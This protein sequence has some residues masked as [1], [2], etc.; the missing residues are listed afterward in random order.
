MDF[1]QEW[2]DQAEIPV[3]RFASWL[4]ISRSKFYDWRSRYGK[5]NEHNA[6]I[7]RDHWLEQWERER[8]VE[9][10]T[11]N[12]L[13]GY[14]CMAFMMLD[15]DVVAVSPSSVYRVL[16]DA[17]LLER[18]NQKTSKKGT[19]FVQ[20]I[21]PHEHW[22]VDIT[23]INC[24]GTFYYLFVIVDGFSRYIIHWD[25]RAAMKETDVE[26]IIQE[27][28]EKFPGVKPRI[29]SDNGPQFI[30]R[31]FKAFIKFTGMTHVRTS[32]Y[33]PQSNGKCERVMKTLKVEGI[34]PAS[35]EDLDE[36]ITAVSR[37][38]EHYNNARLHSGIGYITPRDKL[39]GRANEIF[40]ERDRK[41]EE[42]R[43]QR[44][45]S[46]A[47][48]REQELAQSAA[49]SCEVVAVPA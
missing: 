38:V 23:Y 35:P 47:R 26:F 44:A 37:C 7:P 32:T 25:I 11:K 1:V 6:W 2:S 33:Y 15:K 31:D 4:S 22:H 28:R 20:P 39:E 17:K 19:G 43:A 46:R 24:W 9:Y 29:I 8:I 34:R 36:A 12:P 48:Q 21:G 30:A 13:D 42:A 27:A 3:K 18:S 41:L 49:S 45:A 16:S 14:R 10:Y 5:A 40:A